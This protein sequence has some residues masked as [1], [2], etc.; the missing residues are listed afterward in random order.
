[1]VPRKAT[2]A[3]QSSFMS[4]PIPPF[5][6]FWFF[7]VFFCFAILFIAGPIKVRKFEGDCENISRAPLDFFNLVTFDPDL[8]AARLQPQ[9]RAHSEKRIPSNLFSTFDRLQQEGVGLSL[10]HGEKSG[11]RRQ[12]VGR[13]RLRHRNQR[14]AA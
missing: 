10:S 12:Q 2:A 13:D 6:S 14:G 9:K 7:G 4:P 5:P 3:S 1:M 11:N 8:I